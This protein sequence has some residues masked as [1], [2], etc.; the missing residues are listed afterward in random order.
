MRQPLTPPIAVA[1]PTVETAQ[2]SLQKQAAAFHTDIYEHP[3]DEGIQD[4][5]ADWREEHANDP[6]FR[7][8][9]EHLRWHKEHCLFGVMFWP[10]PTLKTEEEMQRWTQL[11]QHYH[12]RHEHLRPMPKPLEWYYHLYLD[13]KHPHYHWLNVGIVNIFVERELYYQ[14]CE[15]PT[16]LERKLYVQDNRYQETRYAEEVIAAVL[17]ILY[18]QHNREHPRF[19]V[20]DQPEPTPKENEILTWTQDQMHGAVKQAREQL[21]ENPPA[22]LVP[23]TCQPRPQDT[24]ATAGEWLRRQREVVARELTPEDAAD[25][26]QLQSAQM[27]ERDTERDRQL[28]EL[29]D[30][31]RRERQQSL[32]L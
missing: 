18:K 28:F 12:R 20:R 2:F 4:I 15:S 14:K 16:S 5:Y 25:I 6:E 13:P 30:Q 11:R 3:D 27:R 24:V 17:E 10:P 8:Y 32:S 9:L 21:A 26:V 31:I 29:R 22:G 19:L 7:T 1:A 23:P